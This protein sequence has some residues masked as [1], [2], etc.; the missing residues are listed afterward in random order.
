MAEVLQGL[1]NLPRKKLWDQETPLEACPNLAS[2]L[3]AGMIW[4]KRDDCNG[5]AFGGNKVRQM[6]Y[7]LGDAVAKGCDTLLITGAV[8]SNFVRT[9]AASCAKAGL[10]CHVQLE[11]RVSKD[12]TAYCSSGNV[13]LDHLL[14]AIVHHFP[15]GEDEEGAETKAGKAEQIHSYQLVQRQ[16]AKSADLGISD[17]T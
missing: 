14:G 11:N 8:Q 6:E 5:L 10:E 7:Y 16:K 9:A 1:K 17:I 15:V 12:T 3:G 13:M 4:V 2:H